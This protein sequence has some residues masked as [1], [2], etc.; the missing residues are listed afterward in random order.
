WSAAGGVLRFDPPGEGAGPRADIV[1]KDEYGDFELALE[2][3]VGPAGNSG[4][5]FRVSDDA[6]RTY[7]TGAEYQILDNAGHRDGQRAVTSAGSNYALHAP[8]EDVTRPLG[9]WNE[10]RIRVEG[11]RV[12]HWLNGTKLL[13]Y[14]LWTD[15]WKAM[16]AASKFAAMPRYG[17]NRKGHIALQDHGD[18]VRFRNLKIRPL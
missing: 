3:A 17:L 4:I 12:E 6:Q 11:Q 2:W 10:A 18:P 7:E 9:E 13:E 5:F 16:V 1:T 15:E 8:V 14:E